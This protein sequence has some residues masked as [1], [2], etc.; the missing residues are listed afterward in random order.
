MGN[1]KSRPRER[2]R[3]L[4]F[5]GKLVQTRTAYLG[6]APVAPV[7]LVLPVEA[8]V[9]PAFDAVL[10]LSQPRPVTVNKPATRARQ[11]NL[12]TIHPSFLESQKN[13]PGYP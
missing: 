4:S 12:F 8:L 7:A 6:A 5:V 1:N 13:D 9:V 11:S 2:G 10:P 3:L